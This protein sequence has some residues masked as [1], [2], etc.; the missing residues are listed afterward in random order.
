MKALVVGC[1]EC[2]WRDVE[3][4]KSLGQFDKI[5]CV[6]LAAVHWPDKFDVF[7]TLHPEWIAE[8]KKKRLAL[9]YQMEFETVA[10]LEGEVGRHAKHESDR[11]VSYRF[12][13]MNA[14]ASSG[15]Y[16]AKVALEDGC[17]RI[18]LAGVP[19]QAEQG[20]FTRGKEWDQ[21]DAFLR[22]LKDSVPYLKNNV[23][24]VSGLT[25]ELF[26]EPS[27]TWIAGE[28]Q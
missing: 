26:G 19:M 22:G 12:P 15:I 28:P 17:D 5:Y 13:G 10:P 2:V 6:K 24:S 23:R 9:G 20:H 4:A 18:V 16:A 21:C 27:P 14:S 8:Y 7:V 1:A 11:R 25:K 3:I